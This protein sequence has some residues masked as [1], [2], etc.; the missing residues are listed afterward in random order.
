MMLTVM[1]TAS[2]AEEVYLG[3]I[4]EVDRDA[5]RLTVMLVE[6]GD[7]KTGEQPIQVTL[8]K[9]P[10]P[11]SLA[12]GDVVRVW[13]NLPVGTQTLDASRLILSGQGARGKDPT[14]VRRRIGKSR[15]HYGGRGGGKGHGRR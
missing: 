11:G 3:R 2:N 5:G 6:G 10:L 12:P 15:G 4:L 13:G 7:G 8:P 9:K 14:G 1:V